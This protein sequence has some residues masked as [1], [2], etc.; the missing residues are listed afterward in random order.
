MVFSCAGKYRKTWLNHAPAFFGFMALL[1]FDW[2]FFIDGA[3]RYVGL[4]TEISILMI[5]W[6][7]TQLK[8]KFWDHQHLSK[9]WIQQ[10]SMNI[11][12]EYWS[13]I[14]PSE[15]GFLSRIYLV[16][17]RFTEVFSG[18]KKNSLNAT[19]C[20]KNMFQVQTNS[21]GLGNFQP[22]S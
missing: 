20:K 18:K 4:L 15:H 11:M 10:T 22:M 5:V 17:S 13:D 9:I 16:L 21:S 12:I 2:R 14:W 6:T 7:L 8:K 19:R 3:R 1:T